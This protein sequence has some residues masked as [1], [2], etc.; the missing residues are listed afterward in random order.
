MAGSPKMSPLYLEGMI[1]R[2]PDGKSIR[3]S[4][5]KP[6]CATI[7]GVGSHC[8]VIDVIH[9]GSRSAMPILPKLHYDPS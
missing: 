4:P 1:S 5:E 8:D 7:R 3:D 9:T 2:H 6:G